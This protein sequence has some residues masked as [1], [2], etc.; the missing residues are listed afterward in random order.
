VGQK[1]VI[2]SGPNGLAVDR[3]TGQPFGAGGQPIEL[4]LQLWVQWAFLGEVF[5]RRTRERER[6]GRYKSLSGMRQE[7]LGARS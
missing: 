7:R 3:E 4:V 2:E 1:V 5:G 6:A